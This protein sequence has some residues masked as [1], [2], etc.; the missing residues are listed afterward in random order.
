MQAKVAAYQKGLDALLNEVIGTT[1]TQLDS[2]RNVVPTQES[3]MGDLITDAMR[4][5]TGADLAL[6][7]GGGGSRRTGP[8]TLAQH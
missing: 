5:V 6:M 8:M 2:R 4:A 1:E 7:N 3:T